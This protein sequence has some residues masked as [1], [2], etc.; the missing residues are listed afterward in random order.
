VSLAGTRRESKGKVYRRGE[1]NFGVN[2][3]EKETGGQRF[4]LEG[5]GGEVLQRELNITRRE[6][7]M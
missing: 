1:K 7:E 6:G 2:S 4:S 5:A 3:G